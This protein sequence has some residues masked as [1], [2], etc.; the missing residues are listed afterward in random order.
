MLIKLGSEAGNMK[1][2]RGQN[3]ESKI[4]HA[5]DIVVRDEK[6]VFVVKYLGIGRAISQE[7]SQVSCFACK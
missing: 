1:I 4:I 7:L 5:F 6:G 2:C 3:N